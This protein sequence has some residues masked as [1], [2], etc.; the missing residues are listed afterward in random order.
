MDTKASLFNCEGTP[1]KFNETIPVLTSFTA[2]D[3]KKF[4]H[5]AECFHVQRNMEILANSADL[6]SLYII[7][8]GE[9]LVYTRKKFLG[10]ERI[11]KLACLDKGSLFGEISFLDGLPRSAHVKAL[12]DGELLKFSRENLDKIIETEK[13]LAIKFLN[14]LAMLVTS[15]LRSIYSS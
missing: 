9:F 10:M 13:D 2:E 8:S 4:Y 15:R 6:N 11:N 12:T 5:Y 7:L 3:W 14:E 1:C